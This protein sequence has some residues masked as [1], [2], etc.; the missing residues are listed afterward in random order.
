MAVRLQGNC[1][2]VAADSGN[3]TK[4]LQCRITITEDVRPS[5]KR[6]DDTRNSSRHTIFRYRQAVCHQTVNLLVIEGSIPSTGAHA[7][8]CL[9]SSPSLKIKNSG[10]RKF[11]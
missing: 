2:E 8:G 10:D 5:S 9:V 1:N 4:P 7:E 11:G 6:R 3:Y